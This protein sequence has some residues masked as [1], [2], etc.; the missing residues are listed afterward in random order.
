ML[1][2]YK[3][4]TRMVEAAVHLCGGSVALVYRCFWIISSMLR[5]LLGRLWKKYLRRKCSCSGDGG[6]DSI[7]GECVGIL[8]MP[9]W[10]E[11]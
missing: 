1:S 3:R 5:M 10:Y 9:S 4:S 2:S 8:L 7:M 11:S 6:R